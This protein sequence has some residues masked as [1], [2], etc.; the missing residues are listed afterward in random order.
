LVAL[1]PALV[2]QFNNRTQS[3]AWMLSD[4]HRDALT[5]VIDEANDA[6]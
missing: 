2:H 1:F 3:A 4:R 6:R 5:F